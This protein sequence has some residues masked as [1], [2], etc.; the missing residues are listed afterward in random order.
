MEYDDDEG[1]PQP[2]AAPDW[3]HA[4]REV[5]LVVLHTGV[6]ARRIYLPATRPRDL[7]PEEWQILLALALVETGEAQPPT[8]TLAYL[9]AA[10]TLSQEG[11]YDG[12]MTLIDLGFVTDVR[13]EEDD[14]PPRF[15]PS[16]LGW[17][18]AERYI[19]RGARF[20]PGWPPAAGHPG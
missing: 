7:R 3:D 18:A 8:G 1:A 2:E 20:L 9:A 19:R 10:L 11:V 15:A 16:E 17:W 6:L 5:G 13:A 14:D 12:L 4:L